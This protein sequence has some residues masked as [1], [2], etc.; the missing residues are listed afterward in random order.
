MA[1]GQWK[2]SDQSGLQDQ[3]DDL[4]GASG[5]DQQAA[6]QV[7]VA[8]K[9]GQQHLR[10]A[11][12][13][14]RDAED[15]GQETIVQLDAQREIINK[16]S[17][18]IKTINENVDVA[19]RKIAEMHAPLGITLGGGRKKKHNVITLNPSTYVASGGRFVMTGWVQK[20]SKWIRSW[21]NRFFVI[22]GDEI[23]YFNKETETKERGRIELKGARLQRLEVDEG[24]GF[25][26][27]GPRETI[28]VRVRKKEDFTSWQNHIQRAIDGRGLVEELGAS[29]AATDGGG[30][31]MG[32]GGVMDTGAGGAGAG[33]SEEDQL[34]D[35]IMD[36]LG[37]LDGMARTIK[38]EVGEQNTA[39][40]SLQSDML[41]VDGRLKK[42]NRSMRRL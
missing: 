15:E 24:F 33:A 10:D 36:S 29:T 6:A 26:I 8:K 37:N 17:T 35:A 5:A 39:L 31:S 27:V 25:E 12:R 9:T 16:I 42:A 21:N 23:F 30:G 4:F 11:L 19:D 41:D 38:T 20:R 3:R 7:Q 32:M 13:D 22:F 28:G 40:D 34:L 18:N 14:L 1:F 2:P